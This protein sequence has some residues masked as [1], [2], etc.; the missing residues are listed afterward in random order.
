MKTR[1]AK[2]KRNTDCEEL[3]SIYEHQKI[4]NLIAECVHLNIVIAF[5]LLRAFCT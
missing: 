3:D 1:K 2:K 4:I 5:G